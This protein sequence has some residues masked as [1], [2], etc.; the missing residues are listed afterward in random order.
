MFTH[1]LSL[2]FYQKSVSRIEM[3]AFVDEQQEEEDPK[4][5]E[6]VERKKGRRK[7]PIVLP[8]NDVSVFAL[9]WNSVL[10][11]TEAQNFT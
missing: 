6:W 5:E 9:Q 8:F 2:V 11:A 3:D 7:S 1:R 4:G 10:V